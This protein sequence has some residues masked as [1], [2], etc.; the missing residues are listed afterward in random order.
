M[1]TKTTSQKLKIKKFFS[2]IT[3]GSVW[4]PVVYRYVN[5]IMFLLFNFFRKIVYR[6]F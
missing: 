4:E 5:K 1:N 3:F 6:L 2:L